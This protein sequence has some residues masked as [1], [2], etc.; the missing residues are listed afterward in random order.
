MAPLWKGSCC[1]LLE[2]TDPWSLG[3]PH[4]GLGCGDGRRCC[5]G[6]YAGWRW[7]CCPTGNAVTDVCIPL[8]LLCGSCGLESL[9]A[10][11]AAHA[12]CK[13]FKRFGELKRMAGAPQ[14]C[15]LPALLA[16]S[17]QHCWKGDILHAATPA[18]LLLQPPLPPHAPVGLNCV[19][20]CILQ[21]GR[22]PGPGG[23]WD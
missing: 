2:A 3:E 14:A 21:E 11:V 6:R 13:E 7:C 16:N 20:S 19:R 12:Y 9:D 10:C 17:P 4:E 5:T 1:R 8:P 18:H 15:A 22:H 23:L